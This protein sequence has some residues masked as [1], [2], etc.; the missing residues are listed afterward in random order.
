MSLD[1]EVSAIFAPAEAVMVPDRQADNSIRAPTDSKAARNESVP[2]WQPVPLSQLGE[3]APIPWLWDGYLAAGFITLLTG[4]WKGG[5]TTLV[6]WLLRLLGDGGELAG[7]VKPARVLVVSEESAGLWRRRRDGLAIGDHVHLLPRPFNVRPKLSQWEGFALHVAELVRATGYEL[8]VLDTVPSFWPVTNEN[9]ASEV[10]AALTPL[11]AI[12]DAGAAVLLTH[13]PRKG[14]AAEGQASRGSGA[15]PGFVD[16]ILELRRHDAGN[17]EDRRRV[18]TSFSRFDETPPE[19]VIELGED[20]YRLVGT[21]ADARQTDRLCAIA[22]LLPTDPPGLTGEEL[23]LTWPD[24]GPAKPGK[25]TL[26]LDLKAGAQSGR[27]MQLGS[28]TRND[29]FRYR[30]N[31]A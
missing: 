29:P 25:R 16:V 7:A 4:L 3:G 30:G 14:D 23:I 24:T 31:G 22:E 20:G 8:V 5:K 18:L 11:R 15:L 27:W 12:A 6:A 2:L 1:R 21:K 9:D 26:Q 10:I 13:H 19:V 17:R 28:G